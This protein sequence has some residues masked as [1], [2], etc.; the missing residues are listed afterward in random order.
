MTAATYE[1][2]PC[3][4]GHTLRYKTT[5]NCIQ[6]LKSANK[7]PAY[8]ARRSAYRKTPEHRAV[9]AALQR[10]YAGLP[11]P[12]YAPTDSCECCGAAFADLKMGAHLDHDHATGKFRGWL[13]GK[14]NR[15]IGALG[16]TAESLLKAVAYLTRKS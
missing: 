11:L 5:G 16:D 3:K 8:K 15:A 6:C 4:R 12:A 1:G 10:K 7:D 9:T 2:R 14:C 13:C